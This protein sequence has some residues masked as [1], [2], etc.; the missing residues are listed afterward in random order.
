MFSFRPTIKQYEI[1][2]SGKAPMALVIDSAVVRWRSGRLVLG[3]VNKEENEH[4]STQNI[5][6]WK[7]YP[8][9]RD[10]AHM[11]QILEA[12]LTQP[13]QQ[14]STNLKQAEKEEAELM[15]FYRSKP[16]IDEEKQNGKKNSDR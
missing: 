9:V 13:D 16:Y 11:R 8:D 6:V 3:T 1:L 7:N 10:G 5:V 15:S 14:I 12:H 2:K 4:F